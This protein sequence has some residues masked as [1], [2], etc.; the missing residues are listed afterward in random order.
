MNTE[1]ISE[2]RWE[3]ARMDLAEFYDELEGRRMWDD[4]DD[5]DRAGVREYAKSLDMGWLS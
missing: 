1:Q 4:M 3:D 2:K 5:E